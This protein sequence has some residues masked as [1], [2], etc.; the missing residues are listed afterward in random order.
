MSYRATRSASAS[1]RRAAH[2][3]SARGRLN[4]CVPAGEN[5]VRGTLLDG[6]SRLRLPDGTTLQHALMTACF[7]ERNVVMAASAIPLPRELP[8]WQAALLGCGVVTGSEPCATPQA[9]R[10]GESVAVIG[11]GGV[12]LQVLAAARLAGADPLI[13]VDRD[14]AKLE[15]ALERGATHGVE[16]GSASTAAR[17]L[18]LSGGGVEHAFEVVGIPETMR[19]AWDVLRSGGTAVVVGL[20][21]RGVEVALPAI[22]FLSDKGIR[23]SYYGNGDPL[24]DLPRLAELALS[25]ELDLAGVVTHVEPARG[26]HGRARA[27]ADGRGGAD[28]PRGRLRAGGHRVEMTLSGQ[29]RAAVE[30]IAER[31]DELVA[32]VSD[33]I[34][35]DTTARATPDEPARDERAL[36]EYLA[37]RLAA[38]RRGVRS[39]GAAIRRGGRQ[40]ARSGGARLRG[41]APAGGDVRG[42]GRRTKPPAE[43]PRRRRLARAARALD[44]GSLPRRPPRGMLYGR[45]ACDMKGGIGC[46]VFAAEALAALGIRLAGDLVVCTVTEEESTGAGGLAAVVHGVRADA[47]IVLEPSG[48]RDLHRVP[49]KRHSRRSPCSGD[50]ATRAS[51]SPAGAR[52]AP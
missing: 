37:G 15:L 45:G 1:S 18:R 11:C 38:C 28:G 4:L 10:P 17:V 52:A 9:C 14:P 41:T 44:D 50:R 22:E 49:W 7:A 5:G 24:V 12:G 6:T 30:H 43:R 51:L 3:P 48:P 40:Q 35:F 20:A 19:L 25:G 31:E 47:G 46:M 21:A 34:G 42:V 32:L 36:Q 39:L 33:L 16:A 26:S 29:E 8:L 23:G 2:A 27:A 13:A